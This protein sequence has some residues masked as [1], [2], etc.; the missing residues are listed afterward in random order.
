MI[1]IFFCGI[2]SLVG[3]RTVTHQWKNPELRTLGFHTVYNVGRF[4]RPPTEPPANNRH[5]GSAH[6]YCKADNKPLSSGLSTLVITAMLCR[7]FTKNRRLRRKKY[8]Y[9]IAIFLCV[10]LSERR[11]A[12]WKPTEKKRSCLSNPQNNY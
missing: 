6:T 5:N 2:L 10:A 12:V 1:S 4:D 7:C 3:F 8:R 11:F 9:R